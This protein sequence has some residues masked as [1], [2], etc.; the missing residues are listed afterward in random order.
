MG[1]EVD[2]GDCKAKSKGKDQAR[3]HGPQDLRQIND[4]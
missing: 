2:I 4:V 3:S 1:T